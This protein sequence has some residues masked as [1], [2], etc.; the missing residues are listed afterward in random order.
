MNL[1]LRNCD[2]RKNLDLRKIVD[3]LVVWFKKDFQ[4]PYVWFKKVFSTIWGKI[5]NFCCGWSQFSKIFKT[6]LHFFLFKGWKCPQAYFIKNIKY[7]TFVL[8]QVF[9]L[10]I[11]LRFKGFTVFE[12]RKNVYLRKILGVTKIFLKSRFVVLTF[13]KG[14]EKH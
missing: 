7:K 2:L 11:R 6:C 12:I 5:H 14:K 3:T 4:R 8:F 10:Q 1:D 9:I 13:P